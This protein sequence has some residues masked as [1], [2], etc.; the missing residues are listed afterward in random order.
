M[1]T[2]NHD[3][4]IGAGS[5]LW[6][7]H[8]D[9]VIIDLNSHPARAFASQGQQRSIA[10]AMKLSEGEISREIKGEYPIFLLDDVLSELDSSRRDYL[11]NKIEGRQVIMTT[12]E[13]VPVSDAKIIGV[14]GGNYTVGV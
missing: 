10:L 14:S 4:E 5:T 12:C 8:K 6:G 13:S 11:I 3:R 9:D 2:E 1:L 7:I